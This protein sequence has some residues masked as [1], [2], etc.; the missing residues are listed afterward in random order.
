G[1]EGNVLA[2]TILL[3]AEDV[4]APSFSVEDLI[5]AGLFARTLPERGSG[6]P[7]PV[8]RVGLPRLRDGAPRPPR[9]EALEPLLGDALP[10]AV[11]WLAMGKRVAL[12]LDARRE[13][14]VAACEA[15]RALLFGEARARFTFS[16]LGDNP[17][18]P[19]ASLCGLDA[20][21]TRDSLAAWSARDPDLATFDVGA[22]RWIGAPEV[23]PGP[24]EYARRLVALLR[25][26]ELAPDARVE[27]ARALQAYVQLFAGTRAAG[28]R[29]PLLLEQDVVAD[30]AELVET[31][32]GLLAGER[33]LLKQLRCLLPY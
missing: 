17:L 20:G 16:T 18:L 2:H 32:V 15:M 22:R 8:P 6:G 7:A 4:A 26:P 9:P 25:G 19:A 31:R 11:A 10:E 30:A 29:A 5:K 27:A 28:P 3:E 14:T 1:R 12:V 24:L 33:P 23:A 13:L 21:T